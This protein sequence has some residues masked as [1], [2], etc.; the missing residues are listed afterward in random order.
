MARGLGTSWWR[1]REARGRI[2][3]KLCKDE[4]DREREKDLDCIHFQR[5]LQT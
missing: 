2:V 3:S 4:G 1:W 5:A